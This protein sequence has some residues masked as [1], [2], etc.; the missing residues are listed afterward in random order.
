V[1]P[2]YIVGLKGVECVLIVGPEKPKAPP[3]FGP[4]SIT[5]GC[6]T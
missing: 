3:T 4:L 2:G 1:P 5:G 6:V